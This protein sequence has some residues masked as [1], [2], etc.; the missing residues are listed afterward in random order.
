M[1]KVGR[2]GI[3]TR[4][5]AGLMLAVIG[6]DSCADDRHWVRNGYEHPWVV[7]FIILVIVLVVASKVL[8]R[9]NRGSNVKPLPPE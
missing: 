6:V 1:R 3:K 9:S 4:H 2:V 7:A 5:A 8:V